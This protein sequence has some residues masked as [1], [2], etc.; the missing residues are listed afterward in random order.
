MLGDELGAENELSCTQTRKLGHPG[1]TKFR[2]SILPN[3]IRIFFNVNYFSDANY[4]A[5]WRKVLLVELLVPTIVKKNSP[6]LRETKFFFFFC[7][8]NS[9]PKTLILSQMNLSHTCKPH[10]H[11]LISN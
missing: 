8:Q 7:A 4:M 11:L 10:C 9:P 5:I 2:I 6:Y 1:N 3:S